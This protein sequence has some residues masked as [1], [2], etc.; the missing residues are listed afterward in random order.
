MNEYEEQVLNLSLRRGD[1]HAIR[2]SEREISV[3]TSQPKGFD[4]F[5][6]A[7]SVCFCTEFDGD[8]CSAKLVPGMESQRHA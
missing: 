5:A 6:E 2:K 3:S 7:V 1:L 8:I 4:A